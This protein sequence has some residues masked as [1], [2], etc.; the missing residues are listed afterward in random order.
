MCLKDNKILLLCTGLVILLDIVSNGILFWSEFQSSSTIIPYATPSLCFAN[1]FKC[2]SNWKISSLELVTIVLLRFVLNLCTGIFAVRLGRI[3]NQTSTANP[4]AITTTS[5]IQTPLL[6]VTIHA[7][8]AETKQ[9]E[10]LAVDGTTVVRDVLGPE[11]RKNQSKV[12][13]SFI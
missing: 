4:T 8:D 10:N 7:S 12:Q 2:F 3:K 5:S 9:T 11:G 1:F 6:G 13:I